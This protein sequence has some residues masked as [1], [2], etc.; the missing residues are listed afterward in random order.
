MEI[1]ELKVLKQR[2]PSLPHKGGAFSLMGDP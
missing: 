1:I 2:K